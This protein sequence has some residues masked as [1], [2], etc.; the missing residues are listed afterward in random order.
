M[1]SGKVKSMTINTILNEGIK[2]LK[3]SIRIKSYLEKI[4]KKKVKD[5]SLLD[6]ISGL[7]SL[8]KEFLVLEKKYKSAS[9]KELK[10]IKIEWKVLKV[11][12]EKLLS[13]IRKDELKKIA[14]G[15][16]V[17][18]LLITTAI[19]IKH[20]IDHNIEKI[21]KKVDILPEKPK[22][23][24]IE[25]IKQKTTD[26]TNKEYREK[27]SLGKEKTKLDIADL[28]KMEKDKHIIERGINTFQGFEM[29]KHNQYTKI[30]LMD[31]LKAEC[32]KQKF[33]I[34]IAQEVI[35]VESGWNPRAISYDDS[36]VG[37]MQLN[38]NY[39]QEFATKYFSGKKED[40]H[41]FDPKDNLEAGIKFLKFLIKENN[42][43][44]RAALLDY[45]AGPNRSVTTKG[46]LRYAD[47][48]MLAINKK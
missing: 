23:E 29:P 40:F 35:K 16:G 4:N 3:Y 11:K 5:D 30:E 6:I 32:A 7:S 26:K 10:N 44:L 47:M 17:L 37:L 15:V 38:R 20:G 33:P 1:F 31:M 48:I 12:N 9:K 13:Y 18:A 19:L 36:S 43:D 14:L 8:Q 24:T 34:R 45:N 22:T 27:I 42:G 25:E 21:E 46:T 41:I 28:G 2:H 39:E